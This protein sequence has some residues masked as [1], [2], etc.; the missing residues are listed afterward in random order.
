MPHRR[1]KGKVTKDKCFSPFKL[2][3]LHFD[4]NN[5]NSPTI[6][7]GLAFTKYSGLFSGTFYVR[8]NNFMVYMVYIHEI[9]REAILQEKCLRETVKNVLAD[10]VR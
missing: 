10:F 5:P 4:I 9:I 8:I 7:Y 2:F 1:G 3:V 6:F